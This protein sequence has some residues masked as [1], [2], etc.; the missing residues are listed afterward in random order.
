MVGRT[1]TG[2]AAESALH[3][4]TPGLVDPRGTSITQLA[5]ES[6]FMRRLNRRPLPPGTKATSIA[7]REDTVVPAGVTDL[8]GAKGVTV[9]VPGHLT[10]HTDLPGSAQA[11]REIALGVAGMAPTCQSLVD[12]LTDEVVSDAIRTGETGLGG[13]AWLA[14]RSVDASIGAGTLKPMPRGGTSHE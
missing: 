12:V 8:A 4:L 1:S 3:S 11:K 5:E 2:E 9:S 10:E 7:A 13:A 6:E 14:S